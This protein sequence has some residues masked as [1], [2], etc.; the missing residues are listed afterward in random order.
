V[1]AAMKIGTAMPGISINCMRRKEFSGKFWASFR[2]NEWLLLL[3]RQG[4]I[5]LAHLRNETA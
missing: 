4:M 3:R 2:R 5:N 1:A